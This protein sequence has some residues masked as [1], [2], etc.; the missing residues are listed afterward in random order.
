MRQFKPQKMVGWY[1]V[2]QLAGTAIRAILSS[3]FGSYA[4]KREALAALTESKTY[5]YAGES[6]IWLDYISDTGDGFDST[7]SMA[8]L[9]SEKDITVDQDGESKFLER[10]KFV[11]FGGDQ[12]YPSPSKE[13]YFNRFIGPVEAASLQ[14]SPDIKTDLFAIPGNHDWYDGLTN[15]VKIFCHEKS[16]GGFQ[17]IQNRSYF[18]IKVTTT[19]WIWATDVQLQSDIDDEQVNYFEWVA[20][21]EMV[22]GDNVI[23]FTAEPAWVYNSLR[24]EDLSYHHLEEFER[25]VIKANGMNQILTVAGDLHHYARYSRLEQDGHLRHKITA[26]GGGAF[27][28]P[29]H[30]LPSTLTNMHDGDFELK[31]TFPKQKKSKK[32]TW[33]NLMFPIR[34]PGFGLFLSTIHLVMAYALYTTS[35]LDNDEG[36]IFDSMGVTDQ[37][38]NKD[39]FIRLLKTFGHSP[40][41]VVILLTFVFGFLAFCDGKSSKYKIANL[42]GVFHGFMH[43]L[44]MICSFSFFAW[45]NVSVLDISS[46]SLKM[47]AMSAEV[48]FVGGFMSGVLVG[49]YLL[50]SS[51]LF[52]MHD[53]EAFSSLKIAG[54]KNFLRFHFQGDKLTVY[55]VGVQ[56]MPKWKKVKGIFKS[57]EALKPQLIDKP[58]EIDLSGR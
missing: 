34:N 49:F 52:K 42:A 5:K 20:Q 54:Y 46:G 17:T 21:K 18:A 45:F 19:T 16:I 29:T 47:L 2:K 3:I 8:K 9:I 7:F 50:I 35:H 53:N 55:P 24:H 32:L 36:T 13:E 33:L 23:L 48:F 39:I 4:D 58:I 25:A 30:N 6:E 57:N 15:F 40:T 12:V 14:A 44:L 31:E 11:V 51:L 37:L 22:K 1:E 28:H 27:L 56:R 26:G 38:I 41:A 10:G 43:V